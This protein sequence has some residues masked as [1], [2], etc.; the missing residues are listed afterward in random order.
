MR[1]ARLNRLKSYSWLIF[2]TLTVVCSF[3]AAAQTVTDLTI[4]TSYIDSLSANGDIRYY[5]VPIQSGKKIFV[6]LDK[7][8][9]YY[10]YLSVSEGGLP[11]RGSNYDATDQGVEL[12]GQAGGYAYV[13]VEL[14]QSLSGDPPTVSYSITS[15]DET[16]FPRLTFGQTLSNQNLKWNGDASWYQVPIQAGNKVFALLDKDSRYYTYLAISG[17]GLPDRGSNYDATDQGAELLGQAGGYAY[18]RVELAQSLSGDPSTVS[19]SITAHDETTFPRLTLGQTLSNQELKWNGDKQWMLLKLDSVTPIVISV[20]TTIPWYGS[21]NLKNSGLPIQQPYLSASGNENLEL[22]LPG[23]QAGSYYINVTSNTSNPVTYSILADSNITQT[24]I[25]FNQWQEIAINRNKQ[26]SFRVNVPGST[27]N[28]FF[29]VRKSTKIGHHGTWTGNISVMKEGKIIAEEEGMDDFDAQFKN[30]GGGIYNIIVWSNDDADGQI[31][32]CDHLDSLNLGD[33]HKGL[34][35]KGWGHDWTQVDIPSGVDSLF[36]ETQGFGIYS[37]MNIYY[38]SL[39]N[40]TDHWYFDNYRNGFHLTGKLANPKAG[41]Y[42]FKYEDSDNVEGGTSQE[43]DYLINVDIT[44]I[45][46]RPALKPQ[47]FGLSTY[48][49]GLAPVTIEIYGNKIDS[50]S[51]ITIFNEFDTLRSDTILKNYFNNAISAFFDFSSFKKGIYSLIASFSNKENILLANQLTISDST[52]LN[53]WC[54]IIGSN[55][56]RIERES[57]YIIEYGNSGNFNISNLEILVWLP[58]NVYAKIVDESGSNLAVIN[59]LPKSSIENNGFQIIDWN[60]PPKTSKRLKLKILV[61]N[62]IGRFELNWKVTDL[63]NQFPSQSEKSKI[64][65][66][67]RDDIKYS[68]EG[69]EWY[70]SKINCTLLSCNSETTEHAVIILPVFDINRNIIDFEA[71]TEITTCF[72]ERCIDNTAEVK[73]FKLDELNSLMPDLIVTSGK[74]IKLTYDEIEAYRKELQNHIGHTHKEQPFKNVEANEFD[75]IGILEYLAE[76]AGINSGKGF[77]ENEYQYSYEGYLWKE[78]HGIP[79]SDHLPV[80]QFMPPE[81]GNNADNTKTIDAVSSSTPEDKYGTTGSESPKNLTTE[82]QRYVSKDNTLT[83]RIDFWNKETATAP[84]QQVFVKDTLTTNLNDFT[85]AFTEFGF[86]R[87]TVPLSGGQ[88]FN[89][90][91]DMRPDMNLIVNAEGNYDYNSREISWTFRSLDPITMELTE[92]PLAGFLLPIDTSGYQVGWVEYKIEPDK[93]LPTGAAIINRAWVN[94]DGI[95]PTNP[96]PKEAPWLNTI[97]AV[98]PISEV[99]P[100][101]T[102][103]DS[104]SYRVSWFGE[105]DDGGSGIVYYNIYISEDNVTYKPWI[106]NTSETSAV[107]TGEINHTYYFYSKAKDGAGN[108]EKAPLSFDASILINSIEENIA[109]EVKTLMLIS[110]PNPFNNKTEITY[111]LPENGKVLLQLFDI[112]G[113]LI[114][115]LVNEIQFFGPHS[116]QLDNENRPAGIYFARLAY[117]NS[118]ESVVQSIKIVQSDL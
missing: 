39:S 32:V 4:G 47:I 38:D 51:H 27:E 11:D 18:V 48:E 66:Y 92:D 104:T 95:G 43:R 53:Y 28:L 25:L 8:S 19:Y 31:K 24:D 116:Y 103:L 64:N 117:T 108:I 41:R 70:G 57:S 1:N 54:D 112:H 97:D 118:K 35:L 52:K 80:V 7:E 34:V 105:D 69:Q 45:S 81:K 101:I 46:E 75:C 13:R 113:A 71:W 33:W 23:A 22:A 59:M 37:N 96:A 9:R 49:V 94:F 90:N 77:I 98:A 82:L 50:L 91:I 102:H 56:I 99:K 5:K 44:K 29:L 30:A 36:F 14:A 21:L 40:K 110:R 85:L 20:N 55:K 17:G 6:L 111:N 100:E 83:Y 76:K 79:I 2:F 3:Q 88:Y 60:L 89:V 12:Q 107:F 73:K 65:N 58:N 84:A 86:L 114:K 67:K 15:H 106:T 61:K 42:Y 68:I 10:T 74:K 63:F 115:T 72:D 109:N 78:A 16:T 26:K 87:W 93:N 62:N